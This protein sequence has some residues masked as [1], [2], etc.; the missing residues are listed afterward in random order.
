MGAERRA[1]KRYVVD[2][3]LLEIGGVEHETIDVSPRSVAAIR[4][5]GVDYRQLKAPF[6]FKSRKSA[7]ID[8]SISALRI[9]TERAATIVFEY[10]VKSPAWEKT[11]RRHDVRAGAELDD[12]FG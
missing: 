4:V 5:P 6:R 9:I 7:E 3:L 2:G 10:H 1:L 8:Q 12:V 11:L